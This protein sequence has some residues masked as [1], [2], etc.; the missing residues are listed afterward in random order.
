VPVS[1]S[2][3][4]LVFP[5]F[6][7]EVLSLAQLVE[8]LRVALGGREPVAQALFDVDAAAHCGL[9]HY[10]QKAMYREAIA[11]FQKASELSAGNPYA[12]GVLGHAY[13]LPG[14]RNK[15]LEIITQLDELS[16]SRYVA[17][18]ETA[19][20]WAGLDDKERTLEWLEKALEDR[21]WEV[22]WLKVDPRFDSLRSDPRFVDLLRRMNLK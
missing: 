22:M 6:H 9:R 19:L 20:I 21:S 14:D 2:R 1:F 16:K 5:A 17:P 10:E 3:L 11:E 8:L 18:F 13:A 15:A 12:R 4:T 7:V